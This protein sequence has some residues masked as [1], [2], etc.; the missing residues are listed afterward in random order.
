LSGLLRQGK[1]T[2]APANEVAERVLRN[3]TGGSAGRLLH[4]QSRSPTYRISG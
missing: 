2:G 4:R 3:M 1:I